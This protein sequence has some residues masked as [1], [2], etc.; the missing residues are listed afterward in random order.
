MPMNKEE[1]VQLPAFLLLAALLLS[2]GLNCYL[3]L[4]ADKVLP[5]A[6]LLADS[7]L[8]ESE[9]ELQLAHT[10]LAHCQAEQL[11]KDSVLVSLLSRTQTSA[12]KL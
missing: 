11:R 3:L 5:A 6:D 2:A 8:A 10:Q 1:R 7:R 12:V 9:L 4:A